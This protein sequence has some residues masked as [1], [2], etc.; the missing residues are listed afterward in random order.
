MSAR[1]QLLILTVSI[2]LAFAT[3]ARADDM[4]ISCTPACVSFDGALAVDS[5]NPSFTVSNVGPTGLGGSSPS[6]TAGLAVL[7]PEPTSLTSWTFL[8]K[9]GSI[10]SGTGVP[11]YSSGN[12]FP[13]FGETGENINFTTF[14]SLSTLAGASLTSY[15]AFSFDIGPFD[16]SGTTLGPTFDSN[17]NGASG[18]P[19]G[20]I[21]FPYLL[22]NNASGHTVVNLGPLVVT[23]A[24]ITTPEPSSLSMLLGIGLFGLIISS[25]WRLLK[26]R[27]TPVELATK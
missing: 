2:I 24:P 15:N 20:T 10:F 18:F 16:Q 23:T 1:N 13:L 17:F 4:T 7:L 26:G 14:D 25:R 5:I 6:G 27:D 22:D 19:V 21:F 9:A 11:G 3:K 8:G 12:V